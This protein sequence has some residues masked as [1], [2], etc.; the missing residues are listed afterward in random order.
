MFCYKCGVS[1]NETAK[2][3][4]ECGT[5]LITAGDLSNPYKKVILI[6]C[7]S[8]KV[9][10]IKEIRLLTGASLAEAK[11]MSERTPIILK[12]GV[13]KQEALKIQ[14]TFAMVGANV[15]IK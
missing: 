9:V 2:F 1:N 6:D 3:C 8:R 10:V 15:E 7:G 5:Q 4:R 14:R 12:D 13:T 11:S